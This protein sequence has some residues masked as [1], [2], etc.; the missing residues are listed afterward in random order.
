MV[1]RPKKLGLILLRRSLNMAPVKMF[2][3]FRTLILKP[4]DP[5]PDNLAVY[6]LLVWQSWQAFPNSSLV[7][8]FFCGGV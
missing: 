3:V 5:I 8:V 6:E 7:C 2:E 1:H 4:R